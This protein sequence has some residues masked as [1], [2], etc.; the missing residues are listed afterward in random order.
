MPF[1]SEL[2]VL[3]LL[4]A[5]VAGAVCAVCLFWRH[6]ERLHGVLKSPAG[7]PVLGKSDGMYS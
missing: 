7:V 2:S 3:S 5:V 1:L 4:F 6:P